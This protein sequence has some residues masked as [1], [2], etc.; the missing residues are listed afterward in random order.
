M[1]TANTLAPMGAVHHVAAVVAAASIQLS[2]RLSTSS[3][4]SILRMAQQR[5]RAS[6]ALRVTARDIRDAAMLAAGVRRT[7]PKMAPLPPAHVRQIELAQSRI[8]SGIDRQ[9]TT[10]KISRRPRLFCF[11]NTSS[12]VPNAFA[13]C[14]WDVTTADLQPAAN[15]LNPSVHIW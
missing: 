2:D 10:G 11:G 12:A 6:G 5:A 9:L 3:P 15:D 4:Q 8:K 13:S 14:G 7:T 1:A